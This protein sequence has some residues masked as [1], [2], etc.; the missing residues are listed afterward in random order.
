MIDPD[1]LTKGVTYIVRTRTGHQKLPREHR[2]TYLGVTKDGDLQFDARP[3]FGT[4]SFRAGDLIKARRASSTGK[5]Y[6]NMIV[7]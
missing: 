2:M 3:E 5:H 6:M 4:Q 1:K 7:R